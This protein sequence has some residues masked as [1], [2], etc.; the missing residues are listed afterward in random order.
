MR[1]NPTIA[2]R[3]RWGVL[4]AGLLTFVALFVLTPGAQAVVVNDNGTNAGVALLPVTGERATGAG[5][6]MAVSIVRERLVQRPGPDHRA[7]HPTEPGHDRTRH[8]SAGTVV[9][10]CTRTRRSPSPGIL[11]ARYWSA[12]EASSSSSCAT[13]PTAVGRLNDPY[14]VTTQYSDG[15]GRTGN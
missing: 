4:A 5:H 2:S 3:A 7:G 6:L 9:R 8:P 13:W 11:T 12:P 1:R 14:A 15:S 10:S